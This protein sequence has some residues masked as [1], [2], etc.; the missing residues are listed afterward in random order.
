[1]PFFRGKITWSIVE[2]EYL[3]LHMEDSLEQLSLVL[4]KSFNAVKTK[5]REIKNPSLIEANAAK[6]KRAI[7]GT[8]I[9]R[10]I[11]LGLSVRSGWEAN[12]LRWLNDRK[13]QWE[14]EP[15]TFTF[16]E[17]GIKHGTISYTPDI[18]VLNWNNKGKAWLE[19][20]GYL[21]PEDR[22]KLN[23][24]KKFYPD[25]FGKLIVI[26]ASD[27]VAAYKFFTKI[28]IKEIIFYNDLNKEFKTKIPYWE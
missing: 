21:K 15:Q 8:K 13:L 25:E 11:D 6:S 12:V 26:C 23:R 7:R 24:F 3:K 10:R 28:G 27:K 20:K 5:Q 16:I 2:L 9:G 19:V 18:K 22:A 17:F 1:M 14:Y 4:A